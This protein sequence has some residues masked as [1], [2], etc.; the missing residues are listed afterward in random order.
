MTINLKVKECIY[1]KNLIF[2]IFLYLFRCPLSSCQ[3][4]PL[5]TDSFS[6]IYNYLYFPVDLLICTCQLYNFKL[7]NVK[8]RVTRNKCFKINF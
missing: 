3:N 7:F 1:K 8:A 6:I 4:N 5:S 2:K